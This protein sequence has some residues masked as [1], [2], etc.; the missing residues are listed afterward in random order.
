[1]RKIKDLLKTASIITTP[2]V[3]T[4]DAVTFLVEAELKLGDH[5]L[6]QVGDKFHLLLV[7]EV[8]GRDF[9]FDHLGSSLLWMRLSVP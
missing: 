1:M 7:R 8:E 9:R 6:A 2:A 5:T 4:G 3:E